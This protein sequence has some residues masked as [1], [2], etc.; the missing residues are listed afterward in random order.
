MYTCGPEVYTRVPNRLIIIPR[1]L[2][3]ARGTPAPPGGRRAAAGAAGGG[4]RGTVT[5]DTRLPRLSS[6]KF[7]VQGP[8]SSGGRIFQVPRKSNGN[9][10]HVSSVV[11]QPS[12]S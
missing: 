5:G 8:G 6:F 12:L 3:R 9:L 11:E 1:G 4:G 7:Q 2:R 10:F